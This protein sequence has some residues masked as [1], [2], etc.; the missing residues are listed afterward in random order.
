MRSFFE[1]GEL[2]GDRS[3]H[4]PENTDVA[5]YED[6]W[7]AFLQIFLGCHHKSASGWYAFGTSTVFIVLE[8]FQR[9]APES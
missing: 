3:T 1:P 4:W 2:P 7:D 9:Q 8:L 6:A 5:T